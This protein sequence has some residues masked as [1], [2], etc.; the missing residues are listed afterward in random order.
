VVKEGR[1]GTR[2]QVRAE[3]PAEGSGWMVETGRR[4]GGSPGRCWQE[5]LAAVRKALPGAEA[6]VGRLSLGEQESFVR[7][8][9]AMG[10]WQVTLDRRFSQLV[11]AAVQAV[12]CQGDIAEVASATGV[13]EATCRVLG[14]ALTEMKEGGEREPKAHAREVRRSVLEAVETWRVVDIVPGLVPRM[15]EDAALGRTR[16]L[17]RGSSEEGEV[18]AWLGEQVPGWRT[19]VMELCGGGQRGN[20]AEP[21]ALAVSEVRAADAVMA[22]ER[23]G[24]E[25]RRFVDS[26][27]CFVFGSGVDFLSFVVRAGTQVIGPRPPLAGFAEKGERACWADLSGGVVLVPGVPFECTDDEV[28]RWREHGW[29]RLGQIWER[30][31]SATPWEKALRGA[32][33][34]LGM[35]LAAGDLGVSVVACATAAEMLLCRDSREESIQAPLAERAAFLLGQTAEERRRV[36]DEARRLYRHR[37]DVVHKGDGTVGPR[38]VFDA[39][40]LTWRVIRALLVERQDDVQSDAALREWCLERRFRG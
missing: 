9:V 4:P 22:R 29:G 7:R 18:D 12:A 2:R 16:L 25:V 11:S 21:P 39:V 34:W 30:G 28:G 14:R 13:E 27:R 19:G 33:S 36:W 26:L 1:G 3:H 6:P 40:S 38:E 20:A 10:P 35:A 23:G 32:V 5:L 31:E 37:C 24:T 17:R 15:G 8:V